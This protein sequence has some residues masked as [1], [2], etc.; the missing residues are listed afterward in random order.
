MFGNSAFIT[1]IDLMAAKLVDS[2]HSRTHYKKSKELRF[3]NGN[4]ARH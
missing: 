2:D 3:G 1:I 4:A